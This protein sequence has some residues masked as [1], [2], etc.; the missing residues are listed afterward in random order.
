VKNSWG[1][2]WGEEGFFRII[3]GKGRCG[4]NTVAVTAIINKGIK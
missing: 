4:I 2:S 3:R 1:T